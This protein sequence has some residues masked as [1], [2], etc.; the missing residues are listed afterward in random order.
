MQIN[1]FD[2]FH[3]NIN[4]TIYS[5]NM[6]VLDFIRYIFLGREIRERKKIRERERREE[7][8]RGKI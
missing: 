3:M 5:S 4:N 6:L 8:K 2:D 1:V 7:E